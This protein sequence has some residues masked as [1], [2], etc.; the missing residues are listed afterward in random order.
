M[1]FYSDLIGKFV[2]SETHAR[3]G[4]L[5]DVLFLNGDTPRV[6]G[7]IVDNNNHLHEIPITAL[8]TVNSHIEIKRGEINKMRKVSPQDLRKWW[9]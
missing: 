3:L 2:Y 1:L 5:R 6:N 9:K 4:K 8:R 7:I